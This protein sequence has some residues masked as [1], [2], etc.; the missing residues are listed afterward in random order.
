MIVAG[1]A[2][3]LV[4]ALS[5]TGAR[6]HDTLRSDSRV[7]TASRRAVT[8][9]SALVAGQLALSVVLLVGAVLLIRS[10]QRLQQVDLGLDPAGVITFSVS[11]PAG[12]QPD[13]AAARRMLAAIEDRL[14]TAPGVEAAGAASNL[15]LV[16]AGP[17]DIFTIEG[18]ALPPPGA[19]AWSARY[20]MATPDMFRV[21]RV[22]LK[23]GRLF[24]RSDAVGRPLVAVINETA[25]RMY[26]ANEDAVGRTIRY[27]PLE[28]S[29]S[30]RIV[31]IV[32]DVRS[33]GPNA[34]APPAIYVPF[35]QAPRPPY[36]GRTV[37]FVVR[38]TRD[39]IA[40]VPSLRAAVA[41]IDAGLPL[42][43]VRPMSDVVW[44][45]GS[46]PRFTTLVMS[47]FAGVAF[48]LAALGVYGILAFTV[49]QRRR[50]IGVRVALGASRRDIFRLIVG[51]GMAL[52]L[53]GVLVGIPAA[54]LATR[55][56]GTI[57]SSV[58]STDPLTYVAVVSML[59]AS[60][61]LASYVPARRASRVDPLI[62]LRAD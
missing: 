18:R 46:Q 27:Y 16:S 35:E 15:P 39:P 8:A 20:I 30:I 19:P 1:F 29:P 34:P 40:L 32:G 48:F 56:M 62:V 25:A 36:E 17:P 7:S 28:T 42:A 23:R 24:D 57:L 61:L 52:A 31:G 55:W 33:M 44:A 38:G 60:A 13:P 50:E 9:R 12:R 41:S 43:N 47:F 49:E 51:S 3:G 26:W 58:T 54:L 59:A 2:V 53:I 4:P 45:T 37:T 6:M 14:A 22:P 21:L 11:V 10:Y 5:A